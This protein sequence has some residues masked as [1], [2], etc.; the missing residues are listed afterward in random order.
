[1]RAG[2]QETKRY[3]LTAVCGLSALYLALYLSAYYSF[4][5]GPLL[6]VALAPFAV[7]VCGAPRGMAAIGIVTI[8]SVI[9][10]FLG[11]LFFATYNWAALVALAVLHALIIGLSALALRWWYGKTHLPLALLLPCTFVAGEFIRLG[12]P[13]GIPT[14]ILSLG[15]HQ[16]LWIIQ[17]ADLGGSYLVSFA[18]AT[19]SGAIADVWLLGWRQSLWRSVVPVAACWIAI[20][21]YGGYR[22]NQARSTMRAGPV[23]GVIQSDVPMTGNVSLGYDRERFLHEMLAL[24]D[25]SAASPVK[26][27]LIVWPESMNLVPP[28]NPEW[29]RATKTPSNEARLTQLFDKELRGWSSRTGIPLLVGY[30]A[31]LPDDQAPINWTNYSA[32]ELIDANAGN[33]PRRHYKQRLFPIC[34]TIPWPGTFV[35]ALIKDWVESQ[36]SVRTYGWRTPG[37]EQTIFHLSQGDGG[38]VRYTVAMC[39]EICY[40][41]PCGIFVKGEQGRKPIDFL[42]NISNEALFQRNRALIFE[43]A[44][45]AL[46]A[47][48]GRIGIARSSNTGISGFVKPTG[49][50]YGEVRNARGQVNTGMGAPELPRIAAL[51]EFRREHAAEIA[52]DPAIAKKVEDEIAAIEALRREAG[53]SGQSTQTVYIDSRRTLYSRIGDIL[54]WVLVVITTAGLLG[55]LLQATWRVRSRST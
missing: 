2:N 10:W 31:I 17:I 14:G 5:C 1:V 26:P 51:L 29:R 47:V 9:L 23:I 54:P 4:L 35:H 13:L 22:L 24:S 27:S 39:V 25:R 20:A 53:I 11:N 38:L 19:V 44:M 48:E 16:H 12:G 33:Q 42:V 7:A 45:S 37:T 46:R 15:L 32:A 21:G 8:A 28:M 49:E 36:S 18:I 40:A 34:E 50:M 6:L 43:A 41:Q 52:S 3:S 55:Q 30:D